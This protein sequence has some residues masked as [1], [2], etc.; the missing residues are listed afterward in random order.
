M[1]EIL[2]VPELA[3]TSFS[4]SRSAVHEV[5]VD[6]RVLTHRHDLGALLPSFSESRFTVHE[7]LVGLRVF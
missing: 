4:E 1:D 7:V 6:L 2:G 3:M 5:L